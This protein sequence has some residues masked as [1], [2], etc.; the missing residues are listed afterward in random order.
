MDILKEKFMLRAVDVEQAYERIGKY[1]TRTRLDK[2]IALGSEDSPVYLKTENEQPVVRSYKLRGVLAKLTLLD[3]KED[4]R[5]TAISS[6]NHGVCL[7]YGAGLLGFTP[8]VIFAPHTTPKPKLK[9]IQNFGGEIHFLGQCFDEAN[10]LGELAIEEGDYVKVDSRE[11]PEAVAGQGTAALE[12][13]EQNP[14]I[15][16]LMAPIGSG[17]LITASA[18]YLKERFPHVKI[19]GVEPDY[20]PAMKENLEQGRWTKFFPFEGETILDSLVGGVAEHSYSRADL[21]DELL[22]VNDEEVKDALGDLLWEEKVVVEPDSAACYAAYKKYKDKFKGK[23]VAMILTGANID[24]D[25]FT[26]ILEELIE[27]KKE[28]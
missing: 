10:R 21:I 15:D 3:P 26:E 1:I 7:C 28:K 11:D 20:C 25:V 13:M 14:E 16:V 18:V 9:K 22:L 24:G 17:G 4:K 12:I 8:P 27:R 5:L 23:I 2:S 19:V 6:G